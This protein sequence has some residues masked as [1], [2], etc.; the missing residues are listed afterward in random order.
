MVVMIM[1]VVVVMVAV[2]ARDMCDRVCVCVCYAQYK[3]QFH[4]HRVRPPPTGAHQNGVP[5]P[6]RQ[7]RRHR[8]TLRRG[9][10]VSYGP[11]G[12]P[13]RYIQFVGGGGGARV[14][15]TIEQSG[16]EAAAIRAVHRVE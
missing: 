15:K 1:M 12:R 9:V 14:E 2:A 8:Q 6:V 7:V 16:E 10:G 13:H 4:H 11:D 3:P 5:S